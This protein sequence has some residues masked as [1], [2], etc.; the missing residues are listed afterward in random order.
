MNDSITAHGSTEAAKRAVIYLRVS[1]SA[2]ADKDYGTEGYS[3]PAQREACRRTA[4][5]L[6]AS[7][8]EEYVDRGE[9]AKS[10]D[11]PAL[12]AML[13][14]LRDAGDIDYV[15]VHKVDRLARN[16][17]DDIEIALAIRSAG[18]QLVSAS[19]NI[20]QTPSGTL[21]HGIMATIA[22]FYSQ[23]LAAE[24]RKG[25]VQKVRLGGTP[26]RAPLGYLNVIERID[27]REIRTVR[28]D[29]ERAPHIRWMFEAYASG[30]YLIRE[31][32]DELADRG[33]N[34]RPTP[35][36]PKGTAVTTSMV[37][38]MLANPY[39]M[40]IV[41]FE[42][43]QYQGRHQPLISAELFADVQALKA[44]RRASKEKPHQ[45]PHYLKGSLFCGECGER[46][47]V[48]KTRNRHGQLYP[49]F[50]CLGRQKKRTSCQQRYVPMD[51]IEPQ[52]E[53][54]W[55]SVRLPQ[56][57]RDALR[58]E[59]LALA[60]RMQIEQ[61]EEAGR[62][63]ERLAR[64]DGERE[65]LMTAHYAGAVPLDLLKREQ[66]RL[67]RDMAATQK[68]LARLNAELGA[69]EQGLDTALALVADCHRLYLASPP[70]IRRQ[71]NQAVFEQIYVSANPSGSSSIS[72]TKRSP[73][74]T[75]GAPRTSSGATCEPGS[76][77]AAAGGTW[78]HGFGGS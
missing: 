18:A 48:T 32:A 11:R 15:I 77:H 9:S 68:A 76:V 40:G 29:E 45:H 19:E 58:R 17:A 6:G 72:A 16:R 26:T 27:G 69:V 1:T 39:Y 35:K 31:L 62:L 53:A 49:Y 41:V 3:I 37:E 52:V 44:S 63:G 4:E 70:Y 10:A 51:A 75:D 71:L 46:L 20:D 59:V 47:G 73:A 14:R 65:K 50:Y 66:E 74:T 12:L 24:V 67:S 64:L 38:R 55:R 34:T 28:V 78:R 33:L 22:E 25:L 7:V 57:V 23:N 2:Q 36:R 21:L 60:E 42:G 61:T 13:A 5:G 30:D 54:L 43:V 8:V 56:V